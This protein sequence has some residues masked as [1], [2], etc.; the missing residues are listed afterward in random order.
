MRRRLV[1]GN[2]K[3]N[4]PLAGDA[5]ALA[6][7][8]LAAVAP[9]PRIEVVICPPSVWLERIRRALGDGPIGLGGQTMHWADAGAHTGEI[10]PLMLAGEPNKRLATH[11]IIGHSE[12]RQADGETDHTVALK[13][14]SAL[15]HGLVPIAAIGERLEERRTG[16]VED[17]ITRQL[18]AAVS[19]VGKRASHRFAIAYEPVWAIGTG[20][21]ASPADAQAVAGL[22]RRTLGEVIGAHADDVPI[23]YGG[24][25]TG[26][27]AAIFFEQADI[28]GALVGGASLR[29]DEFAA[30]VQAAAATDELV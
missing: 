24:S 4:P 3:M 2:W 25:V 7:A 11:V 18:R 13:V 22:I 19:E 30:I 20:M 9:S 1:V 21:A 8:I 23:L 16:A 26:Q 5:D 12:R 17:V 29:A 28:D 14:A 15:E 6:A 10:S 27:N